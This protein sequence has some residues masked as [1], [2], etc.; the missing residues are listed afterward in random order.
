MSALLHIDLVHSPDSAIE[1]IPPCLCCDGQEN[2]CL[3]QA[4]DIVDIDL[5]MMGCVEAH[6]V[7]PGCNLH[8][9]TESYLKGPCDS[10][11]LPEHIPPEAAIAIL[12]LCEG[13]APVDGIGLE[14]YVR[15]PV[16]VVHYKVDS[17]Q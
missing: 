6:R 11:I 14:I 1:L 16:C 5:H 12:S 13:C 8:R 7:L 4:A 9:V 3:H 2:I 10:A 15:G 17:H